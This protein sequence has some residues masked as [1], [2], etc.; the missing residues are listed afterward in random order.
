M[1]KIE[2]CFNTYTHFIL[3]IEMAFGEMHVGEFLE[4]KG[5]GFKVLTYLVYLAKCWA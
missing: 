4:Q 2:H 3:I 1:F 5:L